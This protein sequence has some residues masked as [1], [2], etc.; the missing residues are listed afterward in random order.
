MLLLCFDKL[1]QW[2]AWLRH[3][4]FEAPSIPE[5]VQEQR[6]RLI[7]QERAKNLEQEW[8]Q[9]KLQ[10]QETQREAARLKEQGKH[11]TILTC[12]FS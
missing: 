12:C 4:R 8:A 9:R 11:N 5:L 1:V 2:Q 3:T 10:M 6:R 7:I